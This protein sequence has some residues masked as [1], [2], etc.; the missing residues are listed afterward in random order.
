VVTRLPG[1]RVAVVGD[2]ALDISVAPLT[3]LRVGPGGDVPARIGIG[4]GGQAANV[5]V[6]LARAGVSTR[7][8][9]PLA[10]DAA[11]QVL[12]RLLTAEPLE[13]VALPAPRSSVVVARLDGEGER[14]MESDRASFSTA[15]AASVATAVAGC[16]WIHVSGYPLRAADEAAIMI[17]AI[18]RCRTDAGVRLSVGGGSAPMGS[19]AAKALRAAVVRLDPDLLVVDLAEARALLDRADEAAACATALAGTGGIAVVT[20]GASG[21]AAAGASL[22]TPLRVPAAPLPG[23]VLDATGAGDAFTAALIAALSEGPWPPAARALQ[24]ALASGNRL[25]G[26]VARVLGAQGRVT[27]EPDRL[28]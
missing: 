4:P 21:S 27:G 7:L 9:V 18:Q 3:S 15:A 16:R 28:G 8:V 23:E 20:D 14:R 22:G 2:C 26:L 11:G 12:T 1:A 5:A 19:E 25:G 17:D 10:G 13:L 6:R 24:D